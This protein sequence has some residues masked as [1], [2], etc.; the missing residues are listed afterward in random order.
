MYLMKKPNQ[1][2]RQLSAALRGMAHPHRKPTMDRVLS[3]AESI[4]KL[5]D[6][7]L[8][9]IDAKHPYVAISERIH[10]LYM[11]DDRRYASFLYNVLSY[12]NIQRGLMKI[13][14]P[15]IPEDRLNFAVVQTV[16]RYVPQ[17]GEAWEEMPKASVETL[18]VGAYQNGVVDYETYREKGQLCV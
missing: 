6:S 2:F 11:N 16:T 7:D 1:T 13:E 8:L 10:R 4:K 9:A 15:V 14:T 17:E 3:N 5:I 18:L 12:I